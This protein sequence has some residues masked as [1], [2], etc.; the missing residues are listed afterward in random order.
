M[1]RRARSNYPAAVLTTRAGLGPLRAAE[2]RPYPRRAY[3]PL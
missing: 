3:F 2:D 1:T